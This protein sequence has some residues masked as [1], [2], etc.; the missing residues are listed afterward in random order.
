MTNQTPPRPAYRVPDSTVLAEAVDK[1]LADTET[2][3]NQLGR[4]MAAVTAAAVRDA[5]T[6][7]TPGAPF[8]ASA[9]ELVESTDGALFPSGRYWTMAGG[10]RTLTETLGATDAGNVIHDMSEWTAYLD[11]ATRDV[12]WDLCNELDDRDG[13]PAYA[14]DLLRAA[15]QLEPPRPTPAPGPTRMVEV[16]VSANEVDRYPALVDPDDQHDGYVRPW[17]DLDTVRRIAADTQAA[18]E[19]YGHGSIDTVHVLDGTV[20]G[21]GHAVVLLVTW[22]DLGTDCHEQAAEI[23]QPNADGRYAVGGHDWCWFVLDD[24]LKPLIPFRPTGR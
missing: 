14:L 21:T 2:A 4:V 8:D 17:F 9:V 15:A 1:A 12:W 24:D 6:R 13:R 11:D 22:M 7:N 18:A 3:H 20:D 5:L 23:V 10:E 16:M 19:E